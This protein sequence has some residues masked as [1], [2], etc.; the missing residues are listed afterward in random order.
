MIKNILGIIEDASK[1][2]GLGLEFLK[3]IERTSVFCYILD[4]SQDPIQ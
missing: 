2:K 3:H 4:I 1:D